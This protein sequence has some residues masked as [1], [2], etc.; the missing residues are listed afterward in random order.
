MASLEGQNHMPSRY[1]P[2]TIAAGGG[3]G[4][5]RV[6]GVS[7]AAGASRRSDTGARCESREYSLIPY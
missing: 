1:A 3:E 2:G 5:G 7:T 4:P 6:R